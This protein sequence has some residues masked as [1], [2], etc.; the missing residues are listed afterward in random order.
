[1]ESIFSDKD[2]K[3]EIT[4]KNSWVVKATDHQ[5]VEEVKKQPTKKVEGQLA[6]HCKNCDYVRETRAF[7]KKEITIYV[8]AKAKKRES[9][10]K[11]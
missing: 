5:I 7:P 8:G 2:G 6:L 1:M 11:R 4:E 3:K 10:E 9:T